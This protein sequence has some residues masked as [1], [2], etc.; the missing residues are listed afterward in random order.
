MGKG[1]K[2][3]AA[4]PTPEELDVEKYR[5]TADIA[6]ADANELRHK[7]AQQQHHLESMQAAVMDS[8]VDTEEVYQYLDAQMLAQ[9]RERLTSEAELLQA[10]A[11]AQRTQGELQRQLEDLQRESS[12]T[13]E[14]LRSDLA[15]KDNELKALTEFRGIRPQMEA[16]LADLKREVMREQDFRKRDEHNSQVEM[17]RQREVLNKQMMERMQQ[18][19]AK[20]LDIT[21][22]MLDS[23][24]HRTMLENQ[25]MTEEIS[26]QASCMEGLIAQNEKL[27][28]EKG[29]LHR[30]LGLQ[31]EQE[32]AE[33]RRSLARRKLAQTATQQHDHLSA[34]MAQLRV[35][36]KLATDR[37]QVHET[38][39]SKLNGQLG[40]AQRRVGV[41]MKRVAQQQ[42]LIE[43][44]LGSVEHPIVVPPTPNWSLILPSSE[45]VGVASGESDVVIH[46]GGSRGDAGDEWGGG[47]GASGRSSRR[48][49]G[50][51]DGGAAATRDASG[52]ALPYMTEP[53]MDSRG[54]EAHGSGSG[55][56]VGDRVEGGGR[57]G[58][59]AGS[60]ISDSGGGGGMSDG[61]GGGQGALGRGCGASSPR[62]YCASATDVI[63]SASSCR[64]ESGSASSTRA[65]LVP[66]PPYLMTSDRMAAQAG[67]TSGGYLT[68]RD[69][70]PQTAAAVG[71]PRAIS[72]KRAV[73]AARSGVG[74][75]TPNPPTVALGQ[76]WQHSSSGGSY[77]AR[78]GGGAAGGVAT[79]GGGFATDRDLLSAA[80]IDHMER[81]AG[82]SATQRG[83]CFA[84]RAVN[85]RPSSSAR[86]HHAISTGTAP[87]GK[88][89]P[90]T[91]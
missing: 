7:N 56:C 38:T 86:T 4:E 83:S 90:T 78:A 31:R 84:G 17:W 74:G 50:E 15:N 3:K 57:G 11:E 20:F 2:G 63:P 29:A 23:T 12:R 72:G 88:M 77:T 87:I 69:R 53:H 60:G 85:S 52:G 24:V 27:T 45:E 44:R 61:G 73:S 35:E 91:S 47:D 34:E 9:G 42:S 79:N 19:K 67:C 65:R 71:S 8:A 70:R 54:R 75:R 22:E 28:K 37:A 58:D 21:A 26:L 80:L 32:A 6:A 81:G 14:L 41:L 10:K 18:A 76:H 51:A 55:G 5:I 25:N 13:I 68:A 40:A 48:V 1:K 33:V 62:N 46:Q 82:Y 39:I 16:E 59:G 64:A 89:T 30:E 66:S 43:K 36:L 49:G